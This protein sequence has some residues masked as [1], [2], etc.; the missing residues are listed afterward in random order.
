M[1]RFILTTRTMSGLGE[2][3]PGTRQCRA[4]SSFLRACSECCS[5]ILTSSRK[6]ALSRC[7]PYIEANDLYAADASIG[8][9]IEGS[10]FSGLLT[11][12][13]I[14]HIRIGVAGYGR[15]KSCG[16][17]SSLSQRV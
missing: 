16:S 4:S 9:T 3:S 11:R 17:A 7:R 15:S 12:V 8:S 14:G 1:D 13:E 10:L 5:D 2:K 6:G